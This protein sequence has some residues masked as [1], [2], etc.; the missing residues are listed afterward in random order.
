MIKCIKDVKVGEC[1]V[2]GWVDKIRDQKSMQFII[3]RDRSGKLQ[4]TVEKE[5]SPD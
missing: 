1:E 4:V 2:E 3:I 5:K